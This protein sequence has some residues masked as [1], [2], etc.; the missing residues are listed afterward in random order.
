MTHQLYESLLSTAR[1]YGSHQDSDIL[2]EDIEGASL[3]ENYRKRI[4]WGTLTVDAGAGYSVT[5]RRD[6]P[7]LNTIV[8]ESQTLADT[9]LTFLNNPNVVLSTWSSRTSPA[10]IT[11]LPQ[12]GLHP[13]SARDPDRD[14]APAHRRASP[15]RPPCW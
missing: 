13:D 15:M 11:Y 2:T 5:E 12:R 4:P 7:G 9:V 3:A 8:N 1:V 10:P 6:A 14:S